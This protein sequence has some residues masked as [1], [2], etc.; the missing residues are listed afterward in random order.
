MNFGEMLKGSGT[1]GSMQMSGFLKKEGYEYEPV[2]GHY[3]D[4]SVYGVIKNNSIAIA[5]RNKLK[6]ILGGILPFRCDQMTVTYVDE[7]NIHKLYGIEMKYIELQHVKKIADSCLSSQ[8][9]N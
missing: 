5:V 8:G 9:K 3:L 7:F 2:F 1:V 4:E 6:T